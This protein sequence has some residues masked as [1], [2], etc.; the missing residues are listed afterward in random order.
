ML[1]HISAVLSGLVK[2]GALVREVAALVDRLRRPKKKMA[3]FTEAPRCA[4][5]WR[6]SS[7]TGSGTRG[8]YVHS[9]GDALKVA[10]ATLQRVVMPS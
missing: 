7:A 10:A 8:T 9:Q 6:M 3:T 4:S 2:Q 1:N 5:C